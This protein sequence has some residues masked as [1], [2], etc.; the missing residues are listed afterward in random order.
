M[1][2][3]RNKKHGWMPGEALAYYESKVG[4]AWYK[5]RL[6]AIR[7]EDGGASTARVKTSVYPPA[8]AKDLFAPLIT[9]NVGSLL[10]PTPT[11]KVTP[12]N[13]VYLSRPGQQQFRAAIIDAYGRCAVTGT[14]LTDVL[15][16]AHIVPYVDERSNL[17]SNGLCLRADV[18]R[19]YDRNLILIG[20][21][22]M[23]SVADRLKTTA[24][25]KLD[26]RSLRQPKDENQQAD[27]KLIGLRHLFINTQAAEP[28]LVKTEEYAQDASCTFA[29]SLALTRT[30]T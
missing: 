5:R 8:L 12:D 16:A 24:Y 28:L 1:K 7:D 17:I 23:V 26:G 25:A 14:S 22:L 9:D 2:R 4:I 21:D 13:V 19:L 11:E 29:S 30:E 15:E 18:H 20:S 27:R 6:A 3:K 10:V